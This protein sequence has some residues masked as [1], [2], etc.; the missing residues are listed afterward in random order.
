MSLNNTPSHPK[1][2]YTEVNEQRMTPKKKIN[3]H[4]QSIFHAYTQTQT[5]IRACTLTPPCAAS[6]PGNRVAHLYTPPD[7]SN[8]TRGPKLHF[9]GLSLLLAPPRLWVGE[10]KMKLST[11]PIPVSSRNLMRSGLP[12]DT[13]TAF[14]SHT[15]ESY[16]TPKDNRS[17]MAHNIKPTACV[18]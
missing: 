7:C 1:G 15:L 14:C 10:S 2:N 3:G 11:F 12:V 16:A 8:R 18:I 5:H 17:L 6:L 9:N 4:Q 13:P